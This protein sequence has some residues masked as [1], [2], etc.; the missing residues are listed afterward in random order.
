MTKTTK[1]YLEI[2]E[3]P[4]DFDLND[5]EL[6]KEALGEGNHIPFVYKNDL[7]SSEYDYDYKIINKWGTLVDIK[8]EN[9]LPSDVVLT[10][11]MK[12]SYLVSIN[13]LKYRLA[14]VEKEN[15]YLCEELEKSK[16]RVDRDMVLELVAAA[17]GNRLRG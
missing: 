5:E 7:Y 9:L 10:K 15:T 11:E 4:D 14:C 17:N 3:L 1:R 8:L 2:I 6:M 12:D 16:N 13:D